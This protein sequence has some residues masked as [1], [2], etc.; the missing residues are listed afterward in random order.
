MIRTLFSLI[1]IQGW[2]PSICASHLNWAFT[3]GI[4]DYPQYYDDMIDVCGVA[5]SL[6]TLQDFQ[7]F[8]KC[9]GMQLADCNDKGLQ[10][11]TVCSCP[12]C[13][14]CTASCQGLFQIV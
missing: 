7:R 4:N 13:N 10:F 6:A 1:T 8:F 11:P 9:K 3:K 5:P 12:P 2:V 14:Q